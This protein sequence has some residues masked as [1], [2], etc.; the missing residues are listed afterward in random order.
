VKH[1]LPRIFAAAVLAAF[2]T[3]VAHA[4]PIAFQFKFAEPNG[5]AQAN[6]TITFESTLLPNP[7][8]LSIGLPDPS[9]L[10]LDLTVTGSANGNGHFTL[11]DFL[12]I[13]FSTNGGTLDLAHPLVGQPTNDAPW[14]T[15][16]SSGEA[17]DFNLLGNGCQQPAGPTSNGYPARTHAPTAPAAGAP[18]TG[19]W[20]FDLQAACGTGEEMLL[21]SFAPAQRAAH[22][23]PALGAWGLLSLASLLVLGGLAARRKAAKR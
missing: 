20:W 11:A 17:G 3:T 16:P 13:N 22:P 14:G 2:C 19:V 4:A 18:P 12:A 15:V 6:G 5:T 9:V 23:A 21:V 8:D 10:A 1:T 7:A